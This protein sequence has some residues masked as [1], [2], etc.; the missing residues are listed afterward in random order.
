MTDP[1]NLPS[2]SDLVKAAIDNTQACEY[3]I[4]GHEDESAMVAYAEFGVP[5]YTASCQENA[6][7]VTTGTSSRLCPLPPSSD[8]C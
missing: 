5:W 6:A 7:A 2:V 8:S 1:N 4:A 3:T